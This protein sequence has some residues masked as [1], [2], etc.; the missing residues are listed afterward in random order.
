[1]DVVSTIL[2]FIPFL[3]ILWLANLSYRKR[4][5]GD[6]RNERTLKLLAYGLLFLLYALLMLFGMGLL[7]VGLVGVFAPQIFDAPSL[8]AS[9]FPADR[10]P[11]MGGSLNQPPKFSMRRSAASVSAADGLAGYAKT[12]LWARPIW[13]R[14]QREVRYAATA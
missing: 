6:L 5:E 9:G 11:V 1:M 3:V 4:I 12:V 10:L 2:I 13:P 14:G 8:T 7:G